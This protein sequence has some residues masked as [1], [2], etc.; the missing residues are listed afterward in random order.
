MAFTNAGAVEVRDTGAADNGGYFNSN[1]VGAGTDYTQQDLPVLTGADGD[2]NNSTTFTSATG[3]FT[4]AMVG[5]AIHITGAGYTTGWY[6]IRTRSDTNTITLDRNPTSAGGHPTTGAFK[7]GGAVTTI[8]P[9]LSS[10][11]TTGTTIYVK[12]GTYTWAALTLPANSIQA[13]ILQGYKTT[14]GD[15]PMGA[16]RPSITMSGTL[17]C[18]STHCKIADV[19]ISGSI[20]AVLISAKDDTVIVNCKIT[21]SNTGA[22]AYC[23]AGGGS[24]RN[25][26]YG[27]EVT[28]N[29]TNAHAA[30]DGM[31]FVYY[32]YIHDS[33]YG[34][35]VNGSQVVNQIVGCVF[36]TCSTAGIRVTSTGRLMISGCTV[37]NCTTGI[38]HDSV[39]YSVTVINS[40]V[41]ACTTGIITVSDA[42]TLLCNL[43][44]DNTTNISGYSGISYSVATGD[45]LLNDPANGDFTILAASPA[46]SA[47]LQMNT[48][49][50]TTGTYYN[51]IGVSEIAP[52]LGQMI[53]VS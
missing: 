27:C 11:L 25:G 26:V 20:N 3:G 35:Y 39:G 33:A 44:L 50:G 30:I 41:K 49:L 51:S 4:A 13:Y 38:N 53:S 22:S 29:A 28:S 24:V 14:R 34:Y 6:E 42:G 10:T 48:N 36:D 23:I 18:G 9:P 43:V 47:A 52:F 1:I 21:Q 2:C 15:H 5:N 7:I 16:D 37:Y 46:K 17:T 45:P 31:S 12:K 19:I 40:I 8:D 32:S